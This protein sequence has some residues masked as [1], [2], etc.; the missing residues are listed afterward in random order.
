[1]LA[2]ATH[3]H[4]PLTHHES[5]ATQPTTR[6]HNPILPAHSIYAPS[7]PSF[8]RHPRTYP[9]PHART[10]AR[11]HARTPTPIQFDLNSHL[12]HPQHARSAR[13]YVVCARST[14]D[15]TSDPAFPVV[16]VPFPISFSFARPR[17]SQ[18][19]RSP[20]LRFLRPNRPIHIRHSIPLSYMNRFKYNPRRISDMNPP[21]NAACAYGK[22]PIIHLTYHRTG[23]R[24][25]S[26]P[27]VSVSR[28]SSNP[29]DHADIGGMCR[30]RRHGEPALLTVYVQ[31]YARISPKRSQ[32]SP[33]STRS[34]CRTYS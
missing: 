28:F 23:G 27:Y 3:I 1:M 2:P 29:S 33:D 18:R 11:Q 22:L 17:L 34:Y 21:N 10:P 31:P 15:K 32:P 19:P 4:S 9:R 25:L 26:I 24:S 5:I 13:R 8:V 7:C 30:T 20:S 16:R 14:K 6:T 12:P